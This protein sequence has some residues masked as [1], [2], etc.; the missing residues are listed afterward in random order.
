MFENPIFI[1][2]YNFWRKKYFQYFFHFFKDEKKR[3][4][5]RKHFIFAFFLSLSFC[6][7]FQMGLFDVPLLSF[8]NLQYH[9]TVVPRREARISENLY[10]DETIM[11]DEMLEKSHS[12]LGSHYLGVG[13]LH[14]LSYPNSLSGIKAMNNKNTFNTYPNTYGSL[15]KDGIEGLVVPID[16][17]KPEKDALIIED[18]VLWRRKKVRLLI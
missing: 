12:S 18:T 11:S 2:V 1:F 8:S 3:R 15:P 17:L 7:P 5:F 10:S 16:Q 14:D 6:V 13:N 9:V 4:I